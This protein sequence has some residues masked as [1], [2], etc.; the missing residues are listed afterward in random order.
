MQTEPENQVSRSTKEKASN[1]T[2]GLKFLKIV[3]LLGLYEIDIKLDFLEEQ[4]LSLTQIYGAQNAIYKLFS[5]SLS[6]IISGLST[7]CKSFSSPEF[8]K[9]DAQGIYSI[10][11][12]RTFS[13]LSVIQ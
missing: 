5:E 12:A 1:E 7:S 3:L 11:E 10:T 2:T 9:N 6:A 8:G 4:Y 13:R